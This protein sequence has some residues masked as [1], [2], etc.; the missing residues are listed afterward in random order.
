MFAKNSSGHPGPDLKKSRQPLLKKMIFLRCFV[1]LVVA[2]GIH[3]AAGQCEFTNDQGPM[4]RFWKYF[5]R[6]DG[7]GILS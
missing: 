7:E 1:G 6:N 3:E 2:V 4:L 5:R